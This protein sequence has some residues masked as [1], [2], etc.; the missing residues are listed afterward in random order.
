MN[1]TKPKDMDKHS[2]HAVE[3]AVALFEKEFKG[4][5]KGESYYH[6][7]IKGELDRKTCEAIEIIYR[8]AGWSLVSCKTSSE[9]GEKPG[10]TGLQ[11]YF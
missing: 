5:E 1:V 10:L 2:A 6:L 7:V 4:E 8:N 9:N 11:L 3:D